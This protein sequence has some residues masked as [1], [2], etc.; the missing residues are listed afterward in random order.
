MQ[1]LFAALWWQHNSLK[2]TGHS[3]TWGPAV[4]CVDCGEILFAPRKSTN[5]S[6]LSA[7][8]SDFQNLL[9]IKDLMLKIKHYE[10]SLC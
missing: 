2:H 3:D 7:A 1:W 9:A 10:C 4:L 6:V 8:L 5:A